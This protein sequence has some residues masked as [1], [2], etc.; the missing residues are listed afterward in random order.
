MGAR[1]FEKVAPAYLMNLT[2]TTLM[3]AGF[4]GG[5]FW[6]AAD[7]GRWMGMPS[8]LGAI[9]ATY[10]GTMSGYFVFLGILAAY[11]AV[12][13]SRGMTNWLMYSS[14]VV[15]TLNLALAALF[16]F[17]FRWACAGGRRL[18]FR[19]RR[20]DSAL[21]RARAPGPGRAV[22]PARRRQEDAWDRAPDA[23]DRHLQ[24]TRAVQLLGQQVVLSTMIIALGI[25]SMAANA[26]AG[27]AQ[28]FQ[29]TFSFA[30]RSGAQ[31]LMGHWMGARRF[32]DVNRLYWKVVG[33]ATLVAFLYA[34]TAWLFS[35]WVLGVFTA[36]ESI[37][38]LGRTLLLIA[39]FYEP[40][41]AVNIIG[42]CALK[43]VGDARFPL[44]VGVTFIWGILPVV[45][46]LDRLWGLTITSFW[47]VFAADEIVRAGINLWR[48]RTGKWKRMGIAQPAA[49][50]ETPPPGDALPA[51]P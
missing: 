27:R 16:V 38:K 9:A 25:T 34:G 35:D 23:A 49:P 30:S 44:V 33:R 40:A 12:L 45:F 15:A 4:G 18:R 37:K 42:G 22:P 5:L 3:G 43:S 21:D 48:W 7:I 51:E 8:G 29:I 1:Q 19:H 20:G 14:F 13:S 10:L 24:R 46:V 6:F 39:V 28:M 41:R 47:L 11:N 26:Y 36:D 17:G 2:L 32:S 31:I 50:G